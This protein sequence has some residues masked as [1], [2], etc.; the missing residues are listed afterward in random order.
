MAVKKKKTTYQPEKITKNKINDIFERFST[1]LVMRCETEQD[2]PRLY[3]V[4]KIL[5]YRFVTND[6]GCETIATDLKSISIDNMVANSVAHI[7]FNQM[8]CTVNNIELDTL[9][10]YY[11]RPE[12][13]H[14]LISTHSKNPTGLY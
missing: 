11:S 3:A 6:D 1:P 14:E 2:K 10:K 13:L 5:W 7:Y 4:S 9:R 8:K 12:K